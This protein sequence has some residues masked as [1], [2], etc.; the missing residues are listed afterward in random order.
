MGHEFL[1]DCH[2]D[3][4]SIHAGYDKFDG[5]GA[6][7]TPIYQTSTFAT[8]TVQDAIDIIH[9]EKEGFVYSRRGNPTTAALERKL[10]AIEKGEACTCTA[11]GM[12]AIGATCIGLLKAGDHVVC[13]NTLYGGTDYV[14]R[15][16][17]T[18]LGVSVDFVDTTDLKAVEKAFRPNT[19][20]LYFETPANP[21][22]TLTD[23]RAITEIAHRHNIKVVVDNTFAPPPVQFPLEMGV[24]VVVHSIT[25]YLNGHGDV[26]GGAVI[27][28]W[29][30]V[31]TI[32][33]KGV[34]RICGNPMPPANA[35][36]VLRGLKT[37]DLRVRRHCENA[38]KVA[39]FLEN[40]PYVKKVYYPGLE[41]FPQ[42][43]LAERQMKGL[44]TG[45][46][47]FE[48]QD[49]VNGLCA[50]DAGVALLNNF[51]MIAIAVSLGDVD[52]LAQHPA[53][54]T[55][56]RIPKEIR[57][58]NGISD[59]LIRLSVGLENADDIIRDISQSL[60]KI[61]K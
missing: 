5:K 14:M 44:Y 17:L 32:N 50:M 29:E 25:K 10:A 34:V 8:P 46:I 33:R 21:T 43:E 39:Q 45:V 31:H 24:D 1:K 55:H 53:S 56:S 11:S 7:A 2:F 3:T 4:V 47:S 27:G 52:T 54:M 19:K 35:Y 23:I 18:D 51:Q 12:G 22:M 41:S 49:E 15:T 16:N 30:D 61:R 9:D 36:Y 60:E 40:H 28:K 48:L 59:G 57:V 20:M 6:V 13:N 42:H 38:M 26:I 58:A 37:L